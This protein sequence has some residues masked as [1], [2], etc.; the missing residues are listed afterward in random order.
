VGRSDC[1][2]QTEQRR[3]PAG[4]RILAPGGFPPGL[5]GWRRRAPP[6]KESGSDSI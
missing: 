1:R 5:R 3:L 4:E 6:G 2:A